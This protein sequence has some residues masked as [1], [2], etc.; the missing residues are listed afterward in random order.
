LTK[1]QSHDILDTI[2]EKQTVIM[3]FLDDIGIE[4]ITGNEYAKRGETFN[5]DTTTF[6]TGSYMLNALVSGSIYGGMGSNSFTAIA[7]ESTTGKTFF[8]L[9]IAQTFLDKDPSS[10][11]VI[12]ESENAL[13]NKLLEERGLD[14]N[15][16]YIVPVATIQEFQTQSMKILMEYENQTERHPM[17]FILDSL[18]NLSTTKEMTDI[19]EGNEKRDM[20]RAQVI[21]ATFRV[22]RLKAGKLRV[23]AIITNHTY[24]VVGSM[25]P[26]Q[27]L[28]GGG[29]L[30]YAADTILFLS[31]K[32]EKDGTKVV[33]NIIHVA[34]YKSRLSKEN[35]KIDVRLYYDTGLDRYYGLLEIAEE[36]G[37]VSKI[38]NRFIMPD[39][40]KQYEK[41]VYKEPEKYFTEEV[42]QQIDKQ[43]KSM[44]QYGVNENDEEGEEDGDVPE[45]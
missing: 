39:G 20:T 19:V 30:K 24:S 2:G 34:T 41:S 3:S 44:F 35:Q 23:P 12:F 22:L 28:S 42:L 9:A 15:R 21:R 40:S 31:K 13:S 16:V 11:V 29:G 25:F 4:K 26:T 27:E 45:N 43:C 33:G 5:D 1:Q 38:G 17:L 8:A 32:K 18:G 10:R 14:T 36:I 37:V 6:D 7:G